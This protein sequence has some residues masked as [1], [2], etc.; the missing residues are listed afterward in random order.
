MSSA[1]I[2][3]ACC[4]VFAASAM[5]Q[6]QVKTAPT[7]AATSGKAEFKSAEGKSIGTATLNQTPSGVLID[8]NVRGLPPGEHAFHIHEVGRCDQAD[9]FKSAGGHFAPR[10]HP[11]GFTTAN[12]PHAGDMPN[13]WVAESGTLRTEVLNTRITLRDGEASVFDDNGSALVI[14]AKRD[15][16]RSQPSGDAGD[17]IACAV[18]QK[19]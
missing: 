3:A 8:V 17:R 14:H 5:A 10:G 1:S 12:G 4:F 2:A 13:Q 16:Y 6:G 18:I 7:T 11:H 15:D 19:Q 9:A